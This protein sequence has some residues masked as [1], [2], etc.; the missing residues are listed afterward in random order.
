MEYKV[1]AEPV[2]FEEEF[3]KSRF[4]TYLAR[5]NNLEE[6]RAFIHQIWQEHPK[7]TH[8]CW[9]TVAGV[10]G[11]ELQ[12]YSTDNGEPSGTAGR[13]MLNTLI[14]SQ[15]GHIVAATVRY[16][17]GIL[18]GTGGLC[19]AYASGVQQ[20]L[21]LAQTTTE[22][23]RDLYFITFDY[24]HLGM[25]QNLLGQFNTKIEFQEFLEQ[26]TIEFGIPAEQAEQ[27]QALL[28]DRSAGSL[29]MFKIG[30]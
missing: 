6:A 2:I 14:N 8:V 26:V 21:K 13:P 27:L 4:I 16:F 30:E 18:L 5:V 23:E 15:I 29:F 28:T 7:A 12:Y 1:L 24:E 19:K 10:P 22:V 11:D 9:A 20:A 3:K 25:V 17:G